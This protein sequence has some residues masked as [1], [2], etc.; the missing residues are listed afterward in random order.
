MNSIVTSRYLI[1]SLTTVLFFF[2]CFFS[3]GLVEGCS[4]VLSCGDIRTLTEKYFPPEYVNDMVCIAYY[5]SSWCAGTY[6]DSCCY[7][8][9]Q[10][11]ESY[12]GQVG[13]PNTTE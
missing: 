2:L 5:E 9:W 13:C 11:N 6:N 4:P 10:I 3:A 8:L 1:V 12:L 7:G